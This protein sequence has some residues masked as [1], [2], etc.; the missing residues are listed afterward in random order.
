MK[1]GIVVGKEV[2]P[3]TA[4]D[5]TEKVA[6]NLHV[7]WDAPEQH[8]DGESGQ[9][10]EE[11]FVRFDVTNINIG[12]YC[13]FQ[14]DIMPGKNGLIAVLSDIKVLGKA[15]LKPNIVLAK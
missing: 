6:R 5:G 3:Y 10:V 13:D 9:K 8:Q 2:R 4:K 14:Y 1:K 11:M 15:E 12:D 7:L